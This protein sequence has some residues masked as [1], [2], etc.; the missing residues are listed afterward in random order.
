MSPQTQASSRQV[1]GPLLKVTDLRTAFRTDRGLVKSVDGVSFTLDRGKSLGIVGESGS[2]KTVLSRSIM[3]LLPK[4]NTERSGSVVF[5]GQEIINLSLSERR[6][7]WGKEMSMIFQDPMT[8]LNPVMRV[9]KQLGEGLKIHL[10]MSK[11]DAR[12]TALRLLQD[13]RIPEPEKRLDQY[14]FELSGGMRQRIMI[15]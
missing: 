12:A 8:S 6:K 15:A 4:R 10:G 5:E 1:D 13:V 2:G 7:V 11:A 14:A 9:G 3:G